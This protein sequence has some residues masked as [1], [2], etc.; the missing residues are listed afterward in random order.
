[1]TSNKPLVSVIIPMYNVEAVLNTC[2]DNLLQQT[3]RPLEILMLDDA[4]T[5]LTAERIE[6]AVPRLEDEGLSVK[7]YHASQNGGVAVMRNKGLDLAKGEYIYSYDADDYMEANL[8]ER[9]V[10]KAEEEGADMVTCDWFL[11]YEGKDRHMQQP[12]VENGIQLFE[13]LCYG[14]MKWNVWLFLV[15]RSL[16]EGATPLRYTPQDNMGEDMMMTSMLSLRAG[17]VATVSEA[18]YYYVKTNSGAQTANYQ[19]THWAQVARN[20][21][22]LEQH[23]KAYYPV[24][25]SFLHFLK[26]NLKLPLLISSNPKDYERWQSWYPEANA[27]V[28]KNPYLSMRTKLIQKA[29]SLGLWRLVSLYNRVVMQWLYTLLYK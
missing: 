21:S 1:M 6:Q 24:Q 18:L 4:S 16:F 23:I 28:M 19:D 17:K 2:L 29:A 8:I 15:R 14:T 12:K 9:L 22:S 7:V 3:Y 25:E 11:R 13:Q 27:Y 26:L 5:D 10:A 20:L